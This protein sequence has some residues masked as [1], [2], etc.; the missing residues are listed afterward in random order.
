VDG[1]LKLTIVAKNT[2]SSNET[3]LRMLKEFEVALHQ[4]I[5]D[6]NSVTSTTQPKSCRKTTIKHIDT[7]PKTALS[8]VQSQYVW[9]TEALYIQGEVATLAGIDVSCIKETSSIFELGLDSIDA[10]KLSSR[11][12]QA[13][14]NISVSA[15]MKS[16]TISKMASVATAIPILNKQSMELNVLDDY[17]GKLR[18]YFR[19]NEALVNDAEQMLP[20]TPLQEAMVAK[21]YS[22][23]FSLYFNH[24]IL[25]L[26]DTVD[27]GRLKL[28]W[29]VV[30]KNTP[31]LRTSFYE[32]D[33][34]NIPFSYAQIIHRSRGIRW[35]ITRVRQEDDLQALT[36][37]AKADATQ[38]AT[39]GHAVSITV[40]EGPEKR[41]LIISMAHALYDGWSINLVHQDVKKAYYGDYLLR[42]SI[43]ETLGHILSSSGPEAAKF[44]RNNLS[45]AKVSRFPGCLLDGQRFSKSVQHLELHSSLPATELK[46]FCRMQGVT[47]QALGQTCWAFVLASYVKCLE[48]VFG[49]ILSGR[50]TDSPH[51]VVFPTMNTVTVRAILH[52]TR[53]KMLQY[54][55]EN[56]TNI[57]QYKHYPLRKAQASAN[58]GGQRLFDTLFIYQKRP[59]EPA[60]DPLYESIGGSSVVEVGALLF[61]PLPAYSLSKVPSLH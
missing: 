30:T 58:L 23:N 56:I 2:V 48:V 26:K 35:N 20:V 1:T 44:W 38:L 42:R 53:G 16:L 40:L 22:S 41:L 27:L 47:L 28:A 12:R 52:G 13:G 10:V 24:D 31:I 29:E 61:L 17:E 18:T 50:D 9:T 60:G 33:D 5:E 3:S 6:P 34:P 45:G 19:G 49:T 7:A 32:V 4:L 11:L 25:Q 43:R 15:I 14:I 55:Q 8:E 51:N 59:D 46:S 36:S 37:K 57:V 21:M 39:R 54:I